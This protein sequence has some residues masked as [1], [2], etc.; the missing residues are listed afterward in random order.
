VDTQEEK[1]PI[2]RP[3]GPAKGGTETFT[4]GEF[5]RA[6]GVSANAVYAAI[7]RGEIPAIRVG[8]AIRIPRTVFDGV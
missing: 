7:G 3:R 6:K 2:R 5:S 4:V 8:R 1:I